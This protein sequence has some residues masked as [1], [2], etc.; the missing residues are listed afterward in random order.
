M[1]PSPVPLDLVS[2]SHEES[3]ATLH[4]QAGG[5]VTL[6]DVENGVL[7][8]TYATSGEKWNVQ[9]LLCSIVTSLS[10]TR[11]Y[12]PRVPPPSSGGTMMSNL[13]VPFCWVRG[14]TPMKEARRGIGV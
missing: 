7:Y 11:T 8:G 6:I 1:N 12:E 10:D 13:P 2:C 4:E 14:S 3:D 9:L 5:A